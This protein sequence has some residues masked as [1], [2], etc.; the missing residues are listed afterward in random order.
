M[1]VVDHGDHRE[2]QFVAPYASALDHFNAG[3]AGSARGAGHSKGS[4]KKILEHFTVALSARDSE[5]STI[6][7]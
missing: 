5:A 2:V 6:S 4:A 1:Y 3:R 7:V